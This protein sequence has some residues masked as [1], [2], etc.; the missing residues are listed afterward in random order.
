MIH[1]SAGLIIADGQILLC[2]RLPSDP[3]PLKWEFPGGKAEEDENPEEAL[4][5]ELSEELAVHT[6]DLTPLVSYPY[7]YDGQEE[8]TLHFF[9]VRSYAGRIKNQ[10]FHAMTWIKPVELREYDLLEGDKEFLG[11]LDKHP[12]S[13]KK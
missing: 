12:H 8:I 9:Q 4:V 10:A 1:V 5:R 13:V 2:Q 7:R 6:T 3:H 11:W